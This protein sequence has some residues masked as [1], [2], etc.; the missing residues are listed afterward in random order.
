MNIPSERVCLVKERFPMIRRDQNTSMRTRKLSCWRLRILAYDL[1]ISIS[2]QTRL[3]ER[4]LAVS[5]VYQNKWT[6]NFHSSANRRNARSDSLGFCPLWRHPLFGNLVGQS[7]KALS[8]LGMLLVRKHWWMNTD[9]IEALGRNNFQGQLD[10]T[11]GDYNKL[12]KTSVN[13]WKLRCTS[14]LTCFWG[15]K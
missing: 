5:L 13:H 1:Q 7:S 6:N 15:T 9:I 11:L 10:R 8:I 14:E 12:E 2:R 3:C 4:P